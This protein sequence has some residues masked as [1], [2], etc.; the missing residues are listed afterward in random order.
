MNG[1]ISVQILRDIRDAV[2]ESNTRLDETKSELTARID[3]T[4]ARV[5]ELSRRVV[6]SE[7]RTATAITDLHGTVRDLVTV[8]REQYDLRPRV[9]R[10]EEQIAVLQRRLPG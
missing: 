9:Q 5:E 7:V 2:R 4:N 8:L 3:E 6:Q 1:D 10:C